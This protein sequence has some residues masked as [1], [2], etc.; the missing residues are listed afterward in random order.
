L[1]DVVVDDPLQSAAQTRLQRTL[2]GQP[3]SPD[4]SQRVSMPYNVCGTL[5]S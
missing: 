5:E 2:A 3:A 1:I 4:C